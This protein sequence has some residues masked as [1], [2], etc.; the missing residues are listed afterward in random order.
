MKFDVKRLRSLSERV[1][2]LR[3]LNDGEA[4]ESGERPGG[5]VERLRNCFESTVGKSHQHE[6]LDRAAYLFE[7][8]SS[9]RIRFMLIERLYSSNARPLVHSI[10]NY[11]VD[12]A[13][14]DSHGRRDRIRSCVFLVED[15]LSDYSVGREG[16]HALR[17]ELCRLVILQA[18]ADV[19][20]GPSRLTFLVSEPDETEATSHIVDAR[21]EVFLG[22]AVMNEYL[23][24]QA[25]RYVDPIH[26]VFSPCYPVFCALMS[27]LSSTPT[28]LLG[29][30]YYSRVILESIFEL[31]LDFGGSPTDPPL[32]RTQT[33]C[34]TFFIL[35]ITVDPIP[36]GLYL[37]FKLVHDF[38]HSEIE[39]EL[40]TV[41]HGLFKL[42]QRVSTDSRIDILS[43]IETL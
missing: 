31:L 28:S 8:Q 34:C 12:I 32:H 7:I 14:L 35:L 37:H 26:L 40:I 3:E 2:K 39:N 30:P 25:A 24:C 22:N 18:I 10:F 29:D 38:F 13:T 17:V 43:L 9:E 4:S 15:K 16:H 1:Q 21:L 5:I 42:V 20:D 36:T 6:K 41:F 23:L 27:K 33:L 11:L 19:H